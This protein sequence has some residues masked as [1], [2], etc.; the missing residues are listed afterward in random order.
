MW[1]VR[2]GLKLNV[3]VRKELKLKCGKLVVRITPAVPRSEDGDSRVA[4]DNT[5][6]S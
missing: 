6:C 5:D 3:C 2:K 1:V 4:P